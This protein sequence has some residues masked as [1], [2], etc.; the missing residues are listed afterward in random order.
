MN[1]QEL[2]AGT[3]QMNKKNKIT[4]RVLVVT[5]KSIVKLDLKF[6]VMDSIPISKVRTAA[7]CSADGR[8]RGGQALQVR[9]S[10]CV[11]L[12]SVPN[13]RINSNCDHPPPGKPP[14]I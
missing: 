10:K 3:S 8:A 13:V 4:D 14:G 11:L 1:N 9:L 5:A 7:Y 12:Y 6:K 2:Y